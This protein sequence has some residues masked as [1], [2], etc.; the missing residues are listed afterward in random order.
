M[1]MTRP[2]LDGY[3]A[4]LGILNGHKPKTRR[5]HKKVKSLRQKRR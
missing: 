4:A 5:L 2:Q 3:I 1:Q